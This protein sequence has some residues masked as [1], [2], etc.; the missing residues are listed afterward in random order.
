[1]HL[2]DPVCVSVCLCVRCVCSASCSSTGRSSWR[3][4]QPSGRTIFCECWIRSR[5]ERDRGADGQ[6]SRT[7]AA[8]RYSVRSALRHKHDRQKNFGVFA[9]FLSNMCKAFSSFSLFLLF[10]L[11]ILR[12][13]NVIVLQ[14]ISL[15]QF[16]SLIHC[17]FT[18]QGLAKGTGLF[19]FILLALLIKSVPMGSGERDPKSTFKHHEPI[20]SHKSGTLLGYSNVVL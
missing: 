1:M 7:T 5:G 12:N 20:N 16:Y 19:Y 4:V 6:T 9:V 13:I 8:L 14:I 3:C 15:V 18:A 17:I 2:S 10:S 11:I